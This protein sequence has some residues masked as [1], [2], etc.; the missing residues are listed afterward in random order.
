ML[1]AR[2][3]IE[4]KNYSVS[5]KHVRC[6][7]NAISYHIH[8]VFDNLVEFCRQYL[9]F[10]GFIQFQ[11]RFNFSRHI[12]KCRVQEKC[13]LIDNTIMERFQHF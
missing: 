6:N 7:R 12:V 10:R 8:S 2:F 11:L 9:P 4:I 3:K 13:R 1:Q 5:D